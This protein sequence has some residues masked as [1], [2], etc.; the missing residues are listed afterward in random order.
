MNKRPAG[1]G[2]VEFALAFPI[3]LLLTLGIIEGGRLLFIYAS[4]TS[5]SREAARYGA[6]LDNFNDCA[7]IRDAAKRI[8]FFAGIDDGNIS[9]SYDRPVAGSN[10]I[11]SPYATSCPSGV[12]VKLGDRIIVHVQVDYQPIV[13]MVNFSGF[14]IESE[15]VHTI[16]KDVDAFAPLPTCTPTPS[17]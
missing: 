4:V 16:I 8:G 15:N 1:Q 13:P 12:D 11:P 7:G 5:A 9:I 2:L 10:T 3:F 6:G 14:T 17:P